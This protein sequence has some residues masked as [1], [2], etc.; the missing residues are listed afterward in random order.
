[1]MFSNN[2]SAWAAG[3][4]AHLFFVL[5]ILVGA[6]F[7][8][9]WALRTLDKKSLMQ[10]AVILIVIGLLGTL[11]TSS[12]GLLGMGVMRGGN[13]TWMQEEFKEMMGR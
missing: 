11:L 5:L 4:H 6:I 7:F 9:V 8:V 12:F 3:F 10:W 2:L 1:M 13:N